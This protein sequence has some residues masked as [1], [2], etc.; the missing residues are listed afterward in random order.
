[1][2]LIEM[3]PK[4]LKIVDGITNFNKTTHDAGHICAILKGEK[5]SDHW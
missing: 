1:M 5:D 4:F 3:S 2:E